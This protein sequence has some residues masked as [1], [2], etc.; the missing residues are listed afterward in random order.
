MVPDEHRHSIRLKDKKI[1]ICEYR[2]TN[3]T[4]GNRV[5]TLVPLARIRTYFRQLSMKELYGVVT[6]IDEEV[7]FQVNHNPDIM[8]AHIMR[9]KG[10]LYDITRINIYEGYKTD[11]KL[12]CKRRA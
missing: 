7:L 2:Y 5:K 3:D 8:A 6:Q 12:S 4:V 10:V 11:M 1:E 9:Y